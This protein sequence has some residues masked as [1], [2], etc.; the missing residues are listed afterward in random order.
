[1][2]ALPPQ[3][4]R[5]VS[6]Y[7]DLSRRIKEKGLLDRLPRRYAARTL[8]LGAGFALALIALLALGQ[9]WWQLLVAAAFGVLF[10]Q[11]AF[12]SHDGAHRQIFA[13]GPKNEWAARVL[14]NL[15][16]GLSYGWWMRKH[17]RHHANPNKVGADDDIRPGVLLFTPD[18]AARRTGV[19]G[20]LTARQ[21][22]LF[23]PLLTLEG[24]SL[25][26]GAVRTVLGD[27]GLKHRRTEAALL[28]VRLLGWPAL[29]VAVLGA[30]LG[31][32]FLAV[33]LVVFGV[34]MGASFAPNHKGMPL[35]PRDTRIDFLSR[36]VLTSRNIRGGRG[37]DLLMG[38]LNLQIEHHLFP[39]MPS[40]NL[41][42][43]RP[44]VRAYCA[45]QGVPY[46]EAGL[47]ESYGIVVR[48]LNRVGLGD[49]DPFACPFVV[50]QRTG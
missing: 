37:V 30:G 6:A 13:S 34:Y 28:A 1:M 31:A 38:G 3:A 2:T 17:S 49:R 11:T 14:G 32:A 16:V 50:S 40:G 27:P 46:T 18:D 24:V 5:Q 36:Q 26:V 35:V 33:Q 7:A 45:E 41:R 22:W 15:V 42:R 25:H 12:L 8:L 44:L 39:S 48:H 20:W 43:A 19:L 10:T 47:I 29:V 9:T 23:F 4:H 21:G